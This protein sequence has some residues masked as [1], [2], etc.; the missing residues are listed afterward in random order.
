MPSQFLYIS[1]IGD[2]FFSKQPTLKQQLDEF[3]LA[4]KSNCYFIFTEIQYSSPIFINELLLWEIL[5]ATKYS[6]NLQ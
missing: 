2:F 1:L 3:S 5:V 4:N 6:E